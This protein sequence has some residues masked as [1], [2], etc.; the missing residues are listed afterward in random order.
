MNILVVHNRYKQK[1]G[2]DV[3]VESETK[4]LREMGYNVFTYIRSNEEL[5]NMGLFQKILL[6]FT[7]IFSIKS[8]RE[9]Y[10]LIKE[11]KIDILHAHNTLCVISPSVYY[12]GFKA[13]IP[14]F[15]TIHNYRLMCPG[16]LCLKD[17]KI[18][19]DCIEK[20]LN[21]ALKGKCYRNS[22]IQTL[23]V[24]L[25]LKVHRIVGTYN[26]LNYI[27]ISEFNKE[28]LMRLNRIHGINIVDEQVYV[29]PHFLD[30]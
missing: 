26:R 7:T 21:M 23:T 20:G 10:K 27:C 28:Q 1:G 15:Q 6:P 24:V 13:K 25:M 9:V 16:G 4:L 2:E 22:F 12:A 30:K 3:V 18:C 17:N 19:T 14:V 5:D 8:Y 11:Y 29:K